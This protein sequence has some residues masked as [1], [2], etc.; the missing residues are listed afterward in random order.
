M[1]KTGFYLIKQM[2]KLKII[3]KD[4]K[5]AQEAGLRLQDGEFSLSRWV[6]LRIHLVYCKYCKRFLLQSKLIDKALSQ[7]KKNVLPL[8]GHSFSEDET[9]ELR[10]MITK[11]NKE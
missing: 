7:Q 11:H 1:K 5:A 2:S 10:E 9:K 3:I 6:K 8:P 4:C